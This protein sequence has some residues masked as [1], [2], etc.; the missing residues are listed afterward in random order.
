M[1][2]IIKI[3]S[4]INAAEVIWNVVFH[5]ADMLTKFILGL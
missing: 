2:T 4:V 1:E 3:A 5:V